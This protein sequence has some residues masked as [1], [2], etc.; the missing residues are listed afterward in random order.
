M[1]APGT[2]IS[3]VL[4]IFNEVASLRPLMD[5]IRAALDPT[6]RTYEILCCDD[7]SADGSQQVLREIAA[8]DARVKV[9][10]FA[11]NFGQTAALDAG[12]QAAQGRVIVPMDA[13][14]QNDPA[15]IPRLLA[16]LE[17]DADAVSGWRVNR[18]DAYWTKT[19]PSRLANH[20]VSW[21]TGVDLHDYGC[22]LKA[23]RADVLKEFRLYGEMHRLIPAYVAW[24]G[25][26]VVEMP[27]NHRER[28]FGTTKYNLSKTVRLLLDLVTVRFLLSY[29]TKPLYF[30]GKWGLLTLGTGFLT[31][32]WVLLKKVIWGH[33]LYTDP[34]FLV[35]VFLLMAGGQFV[36]TGLLAEL[37]MRTYFES[38]GKAPW[39]VRWGV[40][41][42]DR[43]PP[44]PA[45]DPARRPPP[46]PAPG[47]PAVGNPA[48]AGPRPT[49]AQPVVGFARPASVTSRHPASGFALPPSQAPAPSAPPVE[50]A[51]PATPGPAAPPPEAP[52]PSLDALA[53]DLARAMPPVPRPPSGPIRRATSAFV[54]PTPTPM[55]APAPSPGQPPPDGR[56]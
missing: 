44:P 25:G 8:Q 21:T 40:N 36:L 48:P 39:R 15:D 26:R 32:L 53:E 19:L 28:R 37:S 18:Q 4:P 24:A 30:M 50:A 33:P 27:V 23:Y 16:R 5:E 35:S 1:D 51:Q 20:L 41:L 17:Q 9:I 45:E 52:A 7:G 43:F 54:P 56:G 2:D 42:G 49:S 31:F 13:D 12:F 22:T 10:A 47:T 29:S 11:R 34:F 3:V 38:R 6:G 46:P 14:L 55:P